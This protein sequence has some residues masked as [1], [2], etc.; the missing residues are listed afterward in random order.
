[1]LLQPSLILKMNQMQGLKNRVYDSLGYNDVG[2]GCW[3]RN[4]LVKTLRFWYIFT[5]ANF[6]SPFNF[7]HGDST[8]QL[9]KYHL[10]MALIFTNV[11]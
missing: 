11:Q 7:L 4:A 5:C 8:L 9:T 6:K 10:Q 1:M 3:S 2:D